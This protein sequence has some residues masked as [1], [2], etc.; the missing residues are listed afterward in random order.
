MHNFAMPVIRYRTGDLVVLD[1]DNE[2]CRCGR[3]FRTVMKIIGRDADIIVTQDGRKLTAIY[4]AFDNSPGLI[5]AKIIQKSLTEIEVQVAMAEPGNSSISERVRSQLQL[6]IGDSMSIY[7][8]EKTPDEI[9]GDSTAKF[10]I[11]SSLLT[12]ISG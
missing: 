7:V 11:V 1:K 12:G 2:P 3:V 5:C 4:T 8:I 10:K 6:L 9:R